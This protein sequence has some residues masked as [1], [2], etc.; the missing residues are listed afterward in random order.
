MT[1]ESE[2]LGTRYRIDASRSEFTVQ[3]FAEGMLSFMGHNPTFAVRRYGGEVQF[4]SDNQ[5]VDSM[6]LVVET[7]TLQLLDR[8]KEKDGAEIENTM[9][10]DVLETHQFP[11]IVFVSTDIRMRQIAQMRYLAEIVGDLSLH[12]VKHRNRIEAEAEINGESLHARGEIWLRQSDYNIKQ[13]KALGGTLKVKDEVK[14][15]FDIVAQV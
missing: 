14:I 11:E 6:L 13:V 1:N 10:D 15:S 12:G 9:L 7:E 5:S 8:V 2:N 4:A 3:A